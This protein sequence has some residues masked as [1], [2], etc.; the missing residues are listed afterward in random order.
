MGNFE[1][2]ASQKILFT[3]QLEYWISIRGRLQRISTSDEKWSWGIRNYLFTFL[4]YFP[5]V[6][7]KKTSGISVKVLMIK[8]ISE[9]FRFLNVSLFWIYNWHVSVRLHLFSLKYQLYDQFGQVSIAEL[10]VLQRSRL[11][12]VV[13]VTFTP[14]SILLFD[15]CVMTFSRVEKRRDVFVRSLRKVC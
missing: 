10:Q 12:I 15:N 5:N 11:H 14:S 9:M 8:H 3:I 13:N 7:T 6:K 2:L 1:Y 4:L